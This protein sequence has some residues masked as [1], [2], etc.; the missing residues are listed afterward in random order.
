MV[1]KVV[2]VCVCVNVRV[3][4]VTRPFNH[5]NPTKTQPLY[6]LRRVVSKGRA[7]HIHG[8]AHDLARRLLGVGD[9]V[10]RHLRKEPVDDGPLRLRAHAAKV[11]LDRPQDGERRQRERTRLLERGRGVYSEMSVC[12]CKTATDGSG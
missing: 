8:P 9:T 4:G 3:G 6:Y 2:C 1:V 10:K 7:K 12:R 11:A 5:N